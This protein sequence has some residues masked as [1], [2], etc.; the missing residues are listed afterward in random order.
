LKFGELCGEL[1]AER[2]ISS[3]TDTAVR[4]NQN[5]KMESL[6]V[7]QKIVVTVWSYGETRVIEVFIT[8]TG[9]FGLFQVLRKP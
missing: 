7:Y 8:L 4:Q 5:Q 2:A 1:D 6:K 3:E 9:L